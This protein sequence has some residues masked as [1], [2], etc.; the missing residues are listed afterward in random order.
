MSAPGARELAALLG[1]R[2][3]VR[4]HEGDGRVYVTVIVRDVV[5]RWGRVDCEVEPV[6]GEGRWSVTLERLVPA[7]AAGGEGVSS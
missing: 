5:P 3:M 7:P 6:E 2:R 1:E 4:L